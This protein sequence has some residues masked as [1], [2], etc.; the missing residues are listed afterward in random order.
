MFTRKDIRRQL[1]LLNI[2]KD[3]VVTIHTSLKAIGEVEGRGEGLLDILIEYFTEDGGI[4][5]VPAHTWSNLGIPDVYT[6]D[7]NNPNTCIGKFPDIAAAHKDCYRSENP[8]HSLAVFG[9]EEKVK[10]FIKADENLNTCASPKSCYGKLYDMDGYILLAGVDQR[11]N[12][13]LHCVDEI[14]NVPNRLDDECSTVTVKRKDGSVIKN[15][16]FRMIYSQ[17]DGV[18]VDVSKNFPKLEPAFEFYGA[19]KYGKLG[20]A[21]LQICNARK[22]KEVTE[23]IYKRANGKEL[24]F[25]NEPLDEKLYK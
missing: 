11:K 2:P 12:T 25:D 20:N 16:S 17:K 24:L 22:L 6:L 19:L 13:F 21:E 14:L 18:K 7:V 3:K 9:E 1:D 4:F 23:L 8:T 15:N 5:T 10:S